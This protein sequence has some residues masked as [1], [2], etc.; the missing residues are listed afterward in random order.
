M[1]ALGAMFGLLLFLQGC[2]YAISPELVART[3]KTL[4]F[5][6]LRDDPDS[7][8]GKTV[9]LGGT[10]VRLAA[11]PTGAVI[12]LVQ[13]PLDYWGK[14]R[15]TNESGGRFLVRSPRPLSPLIYGPGRELT[16]AAEV[17]GLGKA[18]ENDAAYYPLLLARE[19]KL[20]EPQ[21]KTWDKPQWIDPLYDPGRDK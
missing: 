15:R 19:L 2:S 4:S 6:K 12:E 20:W 3:D 5:E 1:N 8:K 9:I 10:V 16:V 18:I 21:Q 7:F 14:P 11:S 17:E 13:K